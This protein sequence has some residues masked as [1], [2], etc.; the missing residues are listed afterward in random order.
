[1]ARRLSLAS[2]PEIAA[3]GVARHRRTSAVVTAAANAPV[4]QHARKRLTQQG[5][6]NAVS[7][8]L[9]LALTLIGPSGDAP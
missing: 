2:T 3:S 6:T 5:S 7:P 8:A 1:M 4:R 9:Y